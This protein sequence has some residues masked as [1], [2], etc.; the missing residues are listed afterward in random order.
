MWRSEARATWALRAALAAAAV[1]LVVVGSLRARAE[2]PLSLGRLERES[3]AAA[4]A[5]LGLTVD[6]SP[7][8]KV[9]G[10]VYVVNQDVFSSQ[11]WHFRLLNFLHRTTRPDILERE[12]LLAPG[13]RW[14]GA[15][16]DESVRNLQAPPP[17]FFADG[18]RF[19]AP[20]LSSVVAIVP[21][22]SPVPGTVDVLAVTRDLWSLRFNTDFEFQKDTL[23]LLVTSLSE[24]NLLGWRKYLSAGFEMDQGRFGVGP[25]YFDPNVGG[26]RLTLLATGTAWYARDTDRYE[27][28]NEMFS[29]RYPLYALASR[30]GAGLDGSHQDIVV[31]HFCDNRL[32]PVEVSGTEVP[33]AYR[34]L[35]L[36]ADANLVR[37]FGQTVIQRL[38]AGYRFDRRRSLALADFPAGENDPGLADEFLAGWAPPPEM[39]SEP[40]LRYEL[41]AARYRVFRDLDTFDLRENRRLGP[42]LALELA[43]GMPAYGADFLAYPMSVTASWAGAPA[44]TGFGVA[45]VQAS[46]RARS[47]QLIDQRLSALFHFASPPIARAG[48]VV[49]T[50]T[51]DVIRADTHGTRFFLGGN[52]GL[53]GYNVGEFQGTVQAAA[54]AEIRTAPIPVGSQ[55]FGA[56][57]FY[58]VGHAAASYGDLVPHHDLGIGLRW[59]IPQLNSSVLRVD[60]AIPTQAG[61]YTQP[62][63]PGRI[64]AGFMQ[65]FWLLDSPKGYLPLH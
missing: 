53:R 34:H 38:T 8:G 6:P 7:D 12:L 57:V 33:F 61:P 18:T 14:D 32:C 21:L 25:T 10:H 60:W 5:Q 44:G 28:N 9:I 54:H 29:L 20:Q 15:L 27:G 4:L 48:R 45:Q 43:A 35:V 1:L 39:R 11:D 22:A 36:T 37:S 46:A 19:A 47:G 40:Y 51:T 58:D 55:R 3:V 56:V 31:R 42:L 26:T 17:L 2:S 41:F 63:L 64:T 62:G 65:S 49:L 13:Q 24:N 50:A 16:A 30:W 52:T 59:L 23:S